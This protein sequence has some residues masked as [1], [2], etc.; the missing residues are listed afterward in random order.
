[1]KTRCWF[2]ALMALMLGFLWVGPVR[3]A[4]VLKDSESASHGD[5]A[6][7][8]QIV[9][10]YQY[11]GF[12]LVQF[13]LAVLSHYSYLLVSGDQALVVDP[14]R[15]VFAYL[16]QAQKEGARIMG[17]LLTH[18]HADFVAGHMEL[19]KRA[20][21]PIFASASSGCSFRYQPL[22]EGSVIEVGEALVK[23]LVTPGHTP[24]SICG[25]VA[26]KSDPKSPLLLLSGDTL[27]IGSI[28]R[29]DLMGGSVSAAA[30]ASMA[31]DTWTKKL[32][33]L[34]D[35][36]ALFPA[37]GAGSLCGAHLSDE[38][39][40]TL[41]AQKETNSFLRHKTRG[42]FIA[43]VLE[44][45]PEAPQYF[46]HNA[47][48][49]KR[50]P[51]LVNWEK[52]PAPARVSRTL[53]DPKR[54]YIVDLR[55][56]QEYAAGHIPNS[57]NIGLRGRL[58]TW[59][60]TMV[61]WNSRLLLYGKPAELQ[62]ATSR[63][64]R[65]GYVAQVITPEDWEKARVPL[66]KSELISPQDLKVLMEGVD[67]PVV[68]DV[69]LPTEWRGQRL[70]KVLNLP[71]NQL[72][73]LAPVKLDPTQPVVTVC[74]SAYRSSLAVG[75]LERL[76]FK[77]VGS[78]DGGTE[79]WVKAGLPVIGTEPQ[80]A[81]PK[82]APT[83]PK[84]PKIRKRAV[85]LPQRI[86]A[87]DLKRTLLDLPGTFEL[88]D[89][90]P[91]EAFADYHLPG[92]V[93]ADV[94]DVMQNPAYLKGTG[95]LILVDRDGSLAMA[96]GGILSQKTWRPIKVLHGGLEAYW[97]DLVLKPAVQATPLPENTAKK[98]PAPEVKGSSE[99]APPPAT[100]APSPAPAKPKKKSA[101]C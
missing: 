53:T 101:G 22:K 34:P 1:M 52:P 71:L 69:R 24:E 56:A 90:R 92:S 32:K 62:E 76:D 42:E 61:P 15:D 66:V 55:S 2:A 10:T 78:L 12:K 6:A 99:P 72:S 67:S 45:L 8:Y 19:A 73:L 28:G 27:F 17:V 85:R 23:I 49:N 50:G 35:N 3:P 83:P 48:M 47:D 38:P 70:G 20:N 80:V 100:P 84:A 13:N 46:K 82:A 65:V 43:A 33:H 44:G 9:N 86:D 97:Q 37:H 39:T 89:I 36:V 79:A 95:P 18:N 14:G 7:T 30:L 91:S 98:S 59:V 26:S 16:D 75:I 81:K 77:Q 74:N 57:V 40:S 64:Y 88:V 58:E 51:Q 31:F 54:Y 4:E 29:P 96:V 63:L 21:C 25:L 60:G 68:V 87:A 11:P 5:E 93:N 41:G 94:V